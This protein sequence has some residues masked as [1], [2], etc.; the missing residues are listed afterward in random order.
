MTVSDPLASPAPAPPVEGRAR[1]QARPAATPPPP[2]ARRRRIF[3]SI[4]S[5]LV[6]WFVVLAGLALAGSAIVTNVMLRAQ[7]DDR[8]DLELNREAERFQVLA[9]RTP[10]DGQGRAMRALFETY[11]A[12]TPLGD[13]QVIMGMVDGRP[14][15]ISAEA[16]T[17]ID[18]LDD[19]VARWGA[20][21]T[22]TFGEID[23][24]AGPLRYLAVPA[25]VGDEH[26][27]LVIGE[28]TGSARHDV[29][30]LT[31]RIVMASLRAPL[32]AAV[33]A[34]GTAGR[35]LRPVRDLARAARSISHDDVSARLDV[36]GDDE[37]A[38]MAD[39]FNDMLDRLEAALD[40]QRR[41]LRD[42]GHEL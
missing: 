6:L 24:P 36:V 30:E 12:S 31:K 27:T 13:E 26:G 41:L 32:A 19:A 40:G 17:R 28:F 35:A 15:A 5:R 29:A 39:T 7:I 20:T 33:I 42:V 25:T 4:R 11:H 38:E 3:G 22:G 21:R 2:P 14:V 9:A 34:W 1:E 37:A 18:Q 8:V 23:T 10:A 16:N